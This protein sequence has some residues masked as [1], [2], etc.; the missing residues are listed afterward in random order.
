[1]AI[2]VPGG[3]EHGIGISPQ[4]SPSQIVL[5][6]V[7]DQCTVR[8]PL[9]VP[10]CVEKLHQLR[11]LARQPL[12]KRPFCGVQQALFLFLD[13]RRTFHGCAALMSSGRP[14]AIPL[15]RHPYATSPLKSAS[16]L[17]WNWNIF[18]MA[19]VGRALKKT[20][21]TGCWSTCV[22]PGIS[23]LRKVGAAASLAD[24]FGAMPV[25]GHS[26]ANVGSFHAMQRSCAGA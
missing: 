7:G 18:E 5:P 25:S 23:A 15:H 10:G 24:S 11:R 22:Q 19:R 3:I 13:G 8:Q 6:R 12:A 20:P 21:Q 9:E 17:I 4:E 1:M 26:I 2:E 14:M 16:C